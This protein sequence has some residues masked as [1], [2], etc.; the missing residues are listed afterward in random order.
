MLH[1]IFAYFLILFTFAMPVQAKMPEVQLATPALWEVSSSQGKGKLYL[2][3]TFH[4]L[5]KKTNWKSQLID[6]KIKNSKKVVFELTAEEMANPASQQLMLSK[7][8]LREDESL[9]A[10]VGPELFARVE[11]AGQA[12]G[13]PGSTLNRMRPWM[14]STLLAVQSARALGFEPGRGVE[15]VIQEKAAKNKAATMGLETM[16]DQVEALAAL[17]DDG[18]RQM[19]EETTKELVNAEKLFSEMLDAWSSGD[20]VKLESSFLSDMQE[21]PKAYDALLKQRNLRWL[22]KFEALLAEQ[23]PIFVAVGAGH[24][25]GPDGMV[26]LLRAKGYKVK[27]LQPKLPH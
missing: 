20:S 13:L 4:L 22:P 17:D 25:V 7:G 14:A 15:A 16:A 12:I 21:F 27:Q 24:L 8:L 9:A 23:Q 18:A 1:R 3:G 5:P 2:L 6:K 11:A 19:L 10:L 26:A